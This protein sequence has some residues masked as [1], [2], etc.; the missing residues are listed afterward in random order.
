MRISARAH[1]L[2][3]KIST[4]ASSLRWSPIQVLSPGLTSE[5]VCLPL[6]FSAKIPLKPAALFSICSKCHFELIIVSSTGRFAPRS[7]RRISC[8]SSIRSLA[9]RSRFRSRKRSA[10]R[11]CCRSKNSI[12]TNESLIGCVPSMRPA[13]WLASSL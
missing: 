13:D 9:V 4:S 11:S 7:A 5:L 10:T 12:S 6:L 2:K 3:I 1:Y 8:R